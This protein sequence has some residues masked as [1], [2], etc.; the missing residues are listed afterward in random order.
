MENKKINID[1]DHTDPGFFAMDFA[2]SFNQMK[3]TLDFT[4]TIQR[5]DPLPGEMKQSFSIKHRTIL[6]DPLVVK[7]LS[8]ILSE[9]VEKY[10]KKFGKIKV[11]KFKAKSKKKRS[12][13]N[14]IERF[15]GGNVYIG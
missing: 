3:F 1:V 12:K 6:M 13:S 2:V 15:S 14:E 10:E 7:N 11:S 8:R 9:M 4:K 5:V